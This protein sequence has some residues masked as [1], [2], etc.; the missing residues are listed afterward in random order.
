MSDAAVTTKTETAGQTD[1]GLVARLGAKARRLADQA[2]AITKD[3][4]SL[5][6]ETE[7]LRAELETAKKA[8]DSNAARKEAD[9]LK[10]ELR[11]IKHRQVFDQQAKDAKVRP[12]AL[13]DLYR[14]S[15]YKAE[16]DVPDPDAIKTLIADQAK[17]RP[18][19]FGDGQAAQTGQQ[20]AEQAK[21]GPGR[22]QGGTGLREAVGK[23]QVTRSQARDAAFMRAHQKEIASGNFQLVD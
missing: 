19:L 4:D 11:T 20:Q 3:R 1:L 2:A 22:G 7:R 10:A 15:E 14:L 13:E 12:E 17:A 8:G 9:T 5:K 6:A 21:P 18:F 16:A 23:L